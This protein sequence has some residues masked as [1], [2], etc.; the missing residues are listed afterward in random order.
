MRGRF[1]L[2]LVAALLGAVLALGACAPPLPVAVGPG[3]NPYPPPPPPRAEA[4]PLPPVSEDPLV[5][6]FGQWEWASTGYVWRPGEWEMLDG[7]SNQYLPGHWAVQGG[8]WVW[9]RGHWL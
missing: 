4:R 2:V 3:P 8:A 5:W 6:R 7:H 1:S 9:E